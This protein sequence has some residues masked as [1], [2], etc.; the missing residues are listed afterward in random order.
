MGGSSHPLSFLYTPS[1]P[2]EDH[3]GSKYLASPKFSGFDFTPSNVY[4]SDIISSMGS[5]GNPSSLDDHALQGFD[6]MVVRYDQIPSSPNFANSSLICDSEPL[7]SSF[8]D[9]DHTQVLESDL[10]CSSILES[11]AI[12]TTLQGGSSSCG[13][14]MR[15]AKLYGV[16]KW[17]I[18]LRLVIRRNKRGFEIYKGIQGHGK[19]KLD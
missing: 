10:Q 13:A 5:I 11:R 14:Q 8:F 3:Y 16:L 2:M 12:T 19:E 4:S 18:L 9:V 15:W 17:Y 1:S 7:N 6:S